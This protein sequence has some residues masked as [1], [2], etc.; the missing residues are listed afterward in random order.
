MSITP[1][2]V[3]KESKLFYGLE[4]SFFIII[5]ETYRPAWPKRSKKN[6][7]CI[8]LFLIA[9]SIA[10]I[11]SCCLGN[12]RGFAGPFRLFSIRFDPIY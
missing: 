12:I 4:R 10:V 6:I 9:Q 2:S 3:V 8:L 11:A 5:S 7:H 1:S